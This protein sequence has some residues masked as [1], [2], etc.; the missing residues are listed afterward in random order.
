LVKKA[1]ISR[2]EVGAFIIYFG[3]SCRPFLTLF[4]NVILSEAFAKGCGERR[5]RS[6]Q[7]AIPSR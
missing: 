7:R 2:R 4:Q 3:E 5:I 1:L 6:N